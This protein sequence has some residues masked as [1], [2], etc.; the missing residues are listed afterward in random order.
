MN[1]DVTFSER[2]AIPRDRKLL[3]QYLLLFEVS[4]GEG[5]ERLINEDRTLMRM[6]LR[7]GMD[8]LRRIAEIGDQA[9]Q[10]GTTQLPD[11]VR[12][13]AT[14]IAYL[15]GSWITFIL[16]GQRRGLGFA[17]LTT[18]F[19]MIL[20]LSSLRVGLMSM[21]PNLL[22]LAVLGGV[23]GL[24]WDTVDSDTVLVGTF[25]IGIAVDD[26]IH[27]LTRF[28]IESLRTA[29]R[30]VALRQTFHIT[31]RAIVQTTVILCLGFSPFAFSDYYSTWIIGTLLPMTLVVALVAD[32]LWVPAL[33]NL[34]WLRFR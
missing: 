30:T 24:A 13:E 12:V 9:A 3:A 25:A 34:G 15:L 5:L 31:G 21:L 29:D 17:V 33:V 7:M 22:P 28:R 6:T 19:M 11:R 32:L 14:G 20:C 1:P 26:T 10:L 16:E 2:Y 4:G 18:A 27:F 8:G 23:L